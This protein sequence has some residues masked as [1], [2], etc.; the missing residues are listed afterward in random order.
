I[1]G[2]FPPVRIADAIYVD[3]GAIENCGLDLA[4]SLGARRIFIL[5][6]GY[7]AS[8]AATQEWAE[9]PIHAPA[10][11]SDG[12]A[13]PRSRRERT[14]IPHVIAS[15]LERTTQ[16]MSR[17]QLDR[18][19]EQLPPGIEAHV[20]RPSTPLGGSAL[21]F[22]AAPQWVEHGYVFTRKYLAQMALERPRTSMELTTD[23][24]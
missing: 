19:L 4:V 22:D 14:M 15:V 16:V 7:D 24:A 5:D 13:R 8:P 10:G 2:I 6:V 11:A 21:D 18:E 3:G 9:P 20:I 23:R 17:Y 12:H 1:P